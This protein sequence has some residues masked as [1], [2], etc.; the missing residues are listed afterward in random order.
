MA[1]PADLAP[2]TLRFGS[3]TEPG[4]RRRGVKRFAYVDERTGREITRRADLE[5]IVRLAVP[6]AWTDVWIAADPASHV[7]ATGRD[8]RGRKQ[9]RY[10][11]AFM[12][13]R[14]AD[15]FDEL[16]PFAMALGRIRRRV[17]RDLRAGELGHDQVVAV[18]VRLLDTT[19]LRVGNPEYARDNGSYGLTTL[20]QRHVRVRGSRLH[21]S[22]PGKSKH[23][24]DVDVDSAP[25]ARIVRRCQHLP[26]QHLFQYEDG[27]ERR[28]ITSTDVNAYLAEHGNAGITA[29]TFRTWN[30]TVMA[31]ERFADA[32]ADG[33]APT[34]NAVNS[35]IDAVADQLGNTRAVCRASYV[36]PAMIDAFLQETLLPTWSRPVGT[37]PSGLTVVER[38]ALRVLKGAR[39]ARRDRVAA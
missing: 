13:A 18:V 26:G 34:A 25:L 15:K 8:A 14:G 11:P 38:R 3:D 39:V 6:P 20:R 19:G 22:F 30:A 21:L 12:A 2:A 28:V 23:H 16:V 31:G 35:V 4:I 32:A 17:A 9:Y 29:K 7:Q 24:F 36:H 5:R 10:H 27:G 37:R 1:D 33:I